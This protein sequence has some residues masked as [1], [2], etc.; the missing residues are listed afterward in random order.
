MLS[1]NNFAISQNLF[2]FFSWTDNEFRDRKLFQ[3]KT[4]SI[5]FANKANMKGEDEKQ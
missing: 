5:I 4:N 1:K 2:S 3:G